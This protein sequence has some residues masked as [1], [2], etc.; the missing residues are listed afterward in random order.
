M[1]LP[2]GATSKDVKVTYFKDRLKVTVAGLSAP[3]L[4]GALPGNIDLD[5]RA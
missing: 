3:A 5:G 1:K 4:E 2:E